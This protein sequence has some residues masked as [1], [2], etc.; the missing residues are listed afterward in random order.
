MA[1]NESD[2]DD[3]ARNRSFYVSTEVYRRYRAAVLA[4][5]WRTGNEADVPASMSADV[6]AHMLTRARDLER[7]FNRGAA[8][9]RPPVRR[10]RGRAGDSMQDAHGF[11]DPARQR[12]GDE[13]E[14][15]ES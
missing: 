15:D 9:P 6:E 7:R 11:R 13:P 5:A 2:D 10:R 4:N 14:A 12:L 8:F 3:P 1:R